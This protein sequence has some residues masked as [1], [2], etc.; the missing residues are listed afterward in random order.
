VFQRIGSQCVSFPPPFG[1]TL[2]AT[3]PLSPLAAFARQTDAR[4]RGRIRPIELVD[5][6]LRVPALEAFDVA[7]GADCVHEI[8]DGEHVCVPVASVESY[9]VFA[10][11]QCST[12]VEVTLV[13]EGSCLPQAR[14]AVREDERLPVGDVYAAPFYELEPGDRC[15]AFEPRPGWVAHALGPPLEPAAFARAV[16][17]PQR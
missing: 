12:T 11:P 4:A 10:D 3:S 15:G 17:Q 6:A 1:S 9:T 5:G 8:R 14:F 16:Q 7:L 2:Y 13:P